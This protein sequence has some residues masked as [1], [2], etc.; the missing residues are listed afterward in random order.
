MNSPAARTGPMSAPAPAR[1]ALPRVIDVCL[2]A[3]AATA[4]AAWFTRAELRATFPGF[5]L[6]DSWI[7]LQFAR[8]VAGGFG[9]SYNPGIPVAGSTA[10]LW[11]MVLVG[12]AWLHL[13]PIGSTKI[14][15]LLLTIVTALLAGRLTEWL[16]R[17]RGA[18]LFAALVLA[19]S[20]RMTWGSLSGMEVSLYA[21]LATGTLLAYLRALESGSAWWGLLAGLAGTARPEV[22]VLF[23]L[24]ATDWAVR[25]WRG[26]LP[27]SGPVRLVA[28]MAAFAIPTSAFVWLNVTAGGHLLPLTFYAKTYRMGTLPS[29]LE[30]RWHDAWLAAWRYPPRFLYEVLAWCET[31]VP[32][33]ALGSLVGALA[34]L[35][36]TANPRRRAGGY[37]VVVLLVVAP[38]AKAVAAPEP[39]LLVHEGRYVFHLLV[40]F[41]VVSMAG[42]VELRRWVRPRWLLTAFLLV[43]L[44][45]LGGALHAEAPSYAAKVKN[46]NDLEVNTA[47]W[48]ARETTPDARIGTNDIGAIAYLSGRFIIDTEG[49][50]T[51]AA[52]QPKRMRRFV[53]FLERERPDLLVIFP[54]WYPEIVARRD[55]FHEIYRIHAR[56][57]AAGGPDLVVYRM[58]WTRPAVVPRLL[59]RPREREPGTANP[60][61][62]VK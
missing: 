45:R 22:F 6:D 3:L 20:P 28:P 40:A 44:L 12:P 54:N 33:L 37:L 10:P 26:R 43:A 29:L 56:K 11:T 31:E 59:A 14:L 5:P 39:P 48:L 2:I 58:P 62:R 52:I 9:F 46:I 32:D 60:R 4:A 16:T 41:V 18:G 27:V 15:G 42:F 17:S 30:G 24:L 61:D 51:P 23:P 38:L 13:D 47:G 53:P 19:L 50:V 55:I 49:L 34:L 35:G 21:A 36:L 1:G 25:W 8:N 7:H 57:V